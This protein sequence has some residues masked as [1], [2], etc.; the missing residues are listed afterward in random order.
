MVNEHDGQQAHWP[1]GTLVKGYDD[2]W[3]H[4]IGSLFICMTI[5][6]YNG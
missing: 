1:I 6:G 4:C 2:Q 5:D 3:V